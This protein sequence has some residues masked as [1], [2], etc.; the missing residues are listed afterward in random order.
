MQRSAGPL[1]PFEV[2]SAVINFYW[3]ARAVGR[4]LLPGS[5]AAVA[6]CWRAAA[7]PFHNGT[8]P[9]FAMLLVHTYKGTLI[10]ADKRFLVDASVDPCWL[11]IGECSH[12]GSVPTLA[13]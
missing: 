9:L 1:V 10:R 5:L 2:V 8:G 11:A 3:A 4:D 6:P 7:E 13:S 12:Q